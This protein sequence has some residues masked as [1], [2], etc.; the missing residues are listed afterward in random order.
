[1]CILYSILWSTFFLDTRY[2]T[3]KMVKILQHLKILKMWYLKHAKQC[4]KTHFSR[5]PRSR[6]TFFWLTHYFSNNPFTHRLRKDLEQCYTSK[7]NLFMDRHEATPLKNGSLSSKWRKMFMLL[8]WV[9]YQG[10]VKEGAEN[11]DICPLA[12]QS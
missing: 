11:R 2:D 12:D 10:C 8:R 6:N 5:W 3:A 9:A 1:M 4:K 7:T